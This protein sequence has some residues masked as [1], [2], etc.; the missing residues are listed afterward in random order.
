MSPMKWLGL[1]KWMA[2]IL[3]FIVLLLNHSNLSPWPIA[4]TENKDMN[5]FNN[6]LII[7]SQNYSLWNDRDTASFG[8]L[9][10]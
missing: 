1:H 6:I 9:N 7:I 10:V 2:D 4:Q 5:N 8:V 3:I